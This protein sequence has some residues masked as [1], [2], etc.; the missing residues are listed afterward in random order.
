[1]IES[2]TIRIECPSCKKISLPIMRPKSICT[3]CGK[4]Y[5]WHELQQKWQQTFVA[6]HNG[7][8][9]NSDK[10]FEP[11]VE[12]MSQS[13]LFYNKLSKWVCFNCGSGREQNEL[14]KCKRCGMY[15]YESTE[16]LCSTCR[17]E[18]QIDYASLS[19]SQIV[20]QF[21]Y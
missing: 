14:A 10:I 17:S 18:M 2:E 1:M 6:S 8:G 20:S 9:N 11:C 19:Q 13:M 16:P 7:S 21:Q 15:D 3:N 5:K 12:C 4:K